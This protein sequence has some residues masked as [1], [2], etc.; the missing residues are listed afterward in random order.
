MYQKAYLEGDE[1]T[2][3]VLLDTGTTDTEA[4]RDIV[5]K[6]TLDTALEITTSLHPFDYSDPTSDIIPK[7]FRPTSASMS[8]EPKA[9]F[10]PKGP[11]IVAYNENEMIPTSSSISDWTLIILLSS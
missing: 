4:D 8:L 5:T 3:S 6:A 7:Q 2:K 10:V 9:K 11:E 1:V